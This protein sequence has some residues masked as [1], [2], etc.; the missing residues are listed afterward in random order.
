M[1]G[2]VVREVQP[3]LYLLRVDDAYTRFFESLWEIPEG[4]TYNAYLLKTSGGAVLF[5]GWKRPFASLLVELLESLVGPDELRYIVVSHAE[6]D[7]SGSLEDIL[8]YA[9][10]ARVL[11]HP[12]AA[13][14]LRAYPRAVERFTPVKDGERIVI[15]GEELVFIYT[16]WLHWPE[17][18]VTWLPKRKVLVSCDIFGGYGIPRG[19]FDD[20]CTRWSEAVRAM[21]KYVVTVIGHYSQWIEKNLAKL[22]A[23]GVEPSI[24]APGHGL[25]WRSQPR[26]VVEIYRKLGRGEPVEKKVTVIYASMYGT[27]ESIVKTLV[28]RLAE[29][30]YETSVYGFTDSTRPPVSE[31]LVDAAASESLVVAAPTYEASLH[32]LVEHVLREVCWKTRGGG[33]RAAVLST[34]GWGGVAAK[35]AKEI[36]ESCGYRVV[37]A[38]Q[39]NAIGPGAVSRETVEEIVERVAA[40]IAG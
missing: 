34:Y 24:I 8:R 33:R 29:K 38:I 35:K 5:D 3:G 18:I 17:T 26:R 15:G 23:Q 19:V 31:V 2:Y 28:C 9:P 36:L 25:V 6:P 37:E 16:P 1:T 10:R 27:I 4:I 12:M 22:E 14:L 21:E 30:G 32:P 40:S 39:V 13:K 7:H 11:G 20:E